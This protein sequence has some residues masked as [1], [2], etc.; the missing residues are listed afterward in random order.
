MLATAQV[1]ANTRWVEEATLTQL[2]LSGIQTLAGPDLG[3]EYDGWVIGGGTG[4]L[5]TRTRGGIGTLIA[6]DGTV[7]AVISPNGGNQL[8]AGTTMRLTPAVG[9]A[10]IR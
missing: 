2:R 3:A 10:A 4:N 5:S 6:P 7:L 9:D 1:T 8:P